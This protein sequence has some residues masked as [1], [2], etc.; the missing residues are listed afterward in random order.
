[1]ADDNRTLPSEERIRERAY[2]LYLSRNADGDELSDWLTAEQELTGSN[3]Q[4]PEAAEIQQSEAIQ[5]AEASNRPE[6]KGKKNKAT[7]ASL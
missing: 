2:E 1:M 4:Q 5:Q 3:S 7:A 6:P